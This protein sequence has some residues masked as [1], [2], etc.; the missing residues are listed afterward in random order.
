MANVHWLNPFD[1]IPNPRYEEFQTTA[2]PGES[3]F[4]IVK[5]SIA[6]N[7]IRNPLVAVRSSRVLICGHKRRGA[8]LALGLESVPVLLEDLDEEQAVDLM[9]DD[10][11]AR[12]KEEQDP[13]KRG[14]IYKRLIGMYGHENGGDRRS[15]RHLNRNNAPLNAPALAALLG[16][17][18]HRAKE[19]IDLLNLIPSVQALVSAYAVK[20]RAGSWLSKMPI[21]AQE[22]F[23][24]QYANVPNVTE[25]EVKAF[26]RTWEIAA[27]RTRRN[28]SALE[29]VAELDPEDDEAPC[30]EDAWLA[31]GRHDLSPMFDEDEVDEFEGGDRVA[32]VSQ[33][34][35]SHSEWVSL[36]RV[37]VMPAA[38]DLNKPENRRTN[39]ISLFD[40]KVQR[41]MQTA[42]RL[43]VEW[44][45]IATEEVRL[46]YE[47]VEMYNNS[48]LQVYLALLYKLVTEVQEFT[49]P[50]RLDVDDKEGEA[51]ETTP[52]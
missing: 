8:A 43:D 38:V 35:P 15:E 11:A 30:G 19:Y 40:V 52:G 48:P 32:A 33:A 13:I 28:H 29:T 49:E 3:S 27:K 36:K 50:A 2:K 7:G 23:A 9:V 20:V 41:H 17:S 24:T 31:E 12:A 16:L 1:L 18:R 26:V 22:A 6:E 14:R 37:D 46:H 21:E 47:T 5:A 10:N 34:P 42:R 25:D 51:S 4:E 44:H 45:E 39:E